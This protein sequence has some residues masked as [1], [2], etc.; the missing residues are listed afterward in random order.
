MDARAEGGHS[1]TGENGEQATFHQHGY[2]SWYQPRLCLQDHPFSI[3]R[4]HH[5]FFSAPALTPSPLDL[6]PRCPLPVSPPLAAWKAGMQG[7]RALPMGS[8][9]GGLPLCKHMVYWGE[10]GHGA[11]APPLENLDFELPSPLFKIAPV[12]SAS[13]GCCKES[14]RPWE[15]SS[16]TRGRS[17]R[18]VHFFSPLVGNNLGVPHAGGD[19]LWFENRYQN[20]PP[21]TLLFFIFTRCLG[22]N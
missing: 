21:H 10:T 15:E 11:P 5:V 2:S 13:Q 3:P 1:G 20:T 18:N 16:G 17:Y 6:F 19:W 12:P 7:S 22:G 9:H 8:Y 14:R 4:L